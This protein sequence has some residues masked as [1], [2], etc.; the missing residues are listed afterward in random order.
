MKDASSVAPSMKEN[1]VCW[2]TCN[3]FYPPSVDLN[4][5][6]NNGYLIQARETRDETFQASTD[7]VGE[8]L[9]NPNHTRS[10]LVECGLNLGTPQP[11]FNVSDAMHCIIPDII[12]PLAEL[13]YSF[14]LI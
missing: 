12:N 9:L 8:W 3:L 13:Y 7:I 6:T 14:E 5:I 2:P 10:R 11:V 1:S 4:N